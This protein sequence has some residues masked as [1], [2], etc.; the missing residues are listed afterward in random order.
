MTLAKSLQSAA[1]NAAGAANYIEDVF[2]TYLY[3][4]NGSTQTITNGIDLAGEGGLTWIKQRNGTYNNILTDTARGV[5]KFLYSDQTNTQET[6][7]GYGVTAFNSDGF[8]VTDSTFYGVNASSSTYASWTF[9]K[10]PKFF[11]VVTFTA[12]TSSGTVNH[13]LNAEPHFVILK[14]TD[15]AEDWWVSH[16]SVGGILYLNLTDARTT[17]NLVPSRTSTTFGYNGLTTGA[18]YVAYLFAHDAGGFGES[19][20]ENVISCGSYTGTGAVG[21]KITL[22]Y[23][24]QWLLIKRTDTAN[25]WY[26]FDTMRG[27]ALTQS[28]ALLPNGTNSDLDY[29]ASFQLNADGVTQ[30]NVNSAFNASGGTY[31]YIAIRRGPM[32]VPESGTSVFAPI[33]RAGT[34]TA[35]TVS[36]G[37]PVDFIMSKGRNPSVGLGENWGEF[38]RLRGLAVLSSNK[39]GAEFTS[40]TYQLGIADF[41][42]NTGMNLSANDNDYG[43]I[44]KSGYNYGTYFLRRAPGFMDVCC[45]TG[46]DTNM[47]INHNLGVVPELMIVKRRSVTGLWFVYSAGTPIPNNYYLRLETTGAQV[48][49]GSQVW[50]NTA[51]TFLAGTGLGISAVGQTYV[52]YLFA[53]CPGVSKVFSYT[54]N[55]SSQTINCGFTGGARFV[56]IKRTDS[57]GDWYVW[58]TARGIVANSDPHLSL[59]TTAAEVTTDDSVD[60]NSTGFIVNQL[61]ATN[62]NVS[63]ATYIG[64]AIA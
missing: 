17:F 3:T 39:T 15:A 2:S 50:N 37:F 18:T 8:N 42:N 19:G 53:S 40:P 52:A 48:N 31:I 43:Y 58:D 63:S 27:L 56:M 57:T 45:Y 41:A 14:R 30:N 51:T 5:S 47:T 13:S 21:N 54:G 25:S 9:R 1:G 4:G 46:D 10:Q 44:N 59:N 34:S 32:K 61:A 36:T 16:A 23:E 60:A 64:L 62:I 6:Y 11:D 55:G 22:G 24:P 12:S 33:A 29:G 26:L 49:A 38:D 20:E 35:T 7:S 28:L